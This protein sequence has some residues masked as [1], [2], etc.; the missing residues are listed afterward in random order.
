MTPGLGRSPGEGNG[1][2]L[3]CSGM[4]M[5]M[6]CTVV[7]LQRE[8]ERKKSMYRVLLVEKYI[9]DGLKETRL[10]QSILAAGCHK[11]YKPWES[12]QAIKNNRFSVR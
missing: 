6:D 3:Q 10:Y 8:K 9:C 4:E 5:S 7:G 12:H 1:Y 2:P 11:M